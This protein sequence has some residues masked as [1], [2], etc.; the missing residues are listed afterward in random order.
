LVFDNQFSYA[1]YRNFLV[2]YGAEMSGD[3]LEAWTLHPAGEDGAI[4]L[5]KRSITSGAVITY[6]IY[7][8]G[9]PDASPAKGSTTDAP[10]APPYTPFL[11]QWTGS[12]G[13][14][15][16]FTDAGV[17]TVTRGADTAEYR[18]LIRDKSGNR[19]LV[20]ITRGELQTRDG[21]T[22]WKV[23]P[24]VSERPFT[25]NGGTITLDG[26]LTLTKNE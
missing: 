13:A 15:Y 23:F 21:V 20:T 22:E 17:Y 4:V 9:A 26:G 2:T 8:K 16:A 10:A 3:R 18:Y 25:K 5:F 11:G 12:D 6:D 1:L 24:T 19:R 14:V 7:E